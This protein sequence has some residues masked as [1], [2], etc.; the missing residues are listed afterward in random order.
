MY[1]IGRVTLLFANNYLT[2]Y[3]ITMEFLHN[4]LDPDVIFSSHQT[5]PTL[6]KIDAFEQKICIR[7]NPNNHQQLYK[8]ITTS[9]QSKSE[10]FSELAIN[11]RTR[12]HGDQHKCLLLH[13]CIIPTPLL[14]KKIIVYSKKDSKIWK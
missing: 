11:F 6:T 12:T 8:N 14:F 2:E 7:H 13:T 3:R 4:F 9:E 5:Y 10:K 1:F